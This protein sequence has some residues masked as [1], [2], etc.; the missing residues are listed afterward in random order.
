MDTRFRG[1]EEYVLFNG[2]LD[3]MPTEW[4]QTVF[5]YHPRMGSNYFYLLFINEANHGKDITEN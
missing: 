5:I 2:Y 3:T 4:D 1:Y